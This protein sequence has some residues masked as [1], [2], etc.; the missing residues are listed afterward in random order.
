MAKFIQM[1]VVVY[2]KDDLSEESTSIYCLT[3]EGRI[4]VKHLGPNDIN[5]KWEEISV[6]EIETKE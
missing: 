3:N 4:L 5:I 6:P 1:Q 2:P